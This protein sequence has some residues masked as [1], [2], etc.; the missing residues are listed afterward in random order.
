[1]VFFLVCSLHSTGDGK[2]RIRNTELLFFF[3]QFNYA[4][5]I[6][7]ESTNSHVCWRSECMGVNGFLVDRVCVCLWFVCVR[8]CVTQGLIVC[9]WE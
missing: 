1:M 4:H 6:H 5:R 9:V 7:I 8:V 2:C 3:T